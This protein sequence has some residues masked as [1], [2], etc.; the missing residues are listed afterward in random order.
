MSPVIRRASS[1]AWTR[2][3]A[4]PSISP[5]A[6]CNGLPCSAVTCAAS[7]SRFSRTSRASARSSSPRDCGGSASQA[8]CAAQAAC[9]ARSASSGL[10]FGTEA[11][12]SPVAGFSTSIH[13]LSV[14]ST[15]APPMK[16]R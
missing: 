10:P 8:G 16:W 3:C 14:E 5:R 7:R 4:V 6:S 13:S 11:I 15:H 1:A 12:T 9:T 2:Y